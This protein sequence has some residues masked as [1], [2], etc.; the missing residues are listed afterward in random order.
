M[1]W[2]KGRCTP[3][4]S[5]TSKINRPYDDGPWGEI[6]AYDDAGRKKDPCGRAGDM[7]FARV[8][9]THG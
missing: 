5:A 1:R 7:G 4:P 6:G 8:T 2:G 3:E 9:G